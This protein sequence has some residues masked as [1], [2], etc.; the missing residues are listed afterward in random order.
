MA[1]TVSMQGWPLAAAFGVNKDLIAVAKNSGVKCESNQLGLVFTSPDQAVTQTAPIKAV[2]ISLLK[3]NSIG[4]A[5]KENIAN[6]IQMNL[7]PVLDY[8]VS[9]P[10]HLK[11]DS[12]DG[13]ADV[14]PDFEVNVHGS[15]TGSLSASD[16]SA[17]DGDK[18]VT[19][20]NSPLNGVSKSLTVVGVPSTKLLHLPLQPFNQD[21]PIYGMV[22]GTSASAKPYMVLIHA[23][24]LAVAFR[25]NETTLSLRM[26]GAFLDNYK[27]ALTPLG[28]KFHSNYASAHFTVP[29]DTKSSP[30][31]VERT[32]GA[33]A[34]G[35]G[36]GN[37]VRCGNPSALTQE[38]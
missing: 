25:Y 24:G 8:S 18:T 36:I 16:P 30:G 13:V 5:S 28:V 32:I 2:A 10:D 23:K 31:L 26:T 9:L 22:A 11:H 6:T 20:D 33:V 4:V 21:T 38:A 15:A 14:G 1:V 35:L 29:K 12:Y 3:N 17:P 7:K 34:F 27:D 19:S 37:V